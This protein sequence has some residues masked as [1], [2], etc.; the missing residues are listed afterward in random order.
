M[1][2]LRFFLILLA[3]LGFNNIHASKSGNQVITPEYIQKIHLQAPARALHL[4]DSAEQHHLPGIRPFETDILRTMCYEVTGECILEEKYARRALASD[5]VQLVPSRKIRMLVAL[6]RSLVEQGKNEDAIRCGEE[7]IGLARLLHDEGREGETL[8]NIGNIYRN[9]NRPGEALKLYRQGI[10]AM[11]KSTNVLILANLSTSYGEMMALLMNEKRLEE[12]VETGKER[13]ALIKRMAGMPGPPPGYIDQQYGFHY[14]KMAYL[15][16]LKGDAQKAEAY[17]RKYLQTDF[18]QSSSNAG[19]IIPY[20]LEAQRY[21]DALKLNQNDRKNYQ[22]TYGNDTINY[23]YLI[24]LD[25]FAQAYRGL[26]LY[27]EADAYQQLLSIV[28]DS[29]YSREQASRA[30]QYAMAFNLHEK[31]LQLVQSQ[32]QSQKR[33]FLLIGSFVVIL[34][35]CALTGIILRNWRVT[36]RRNRIAAKQINELLAQRE[37]ARNTCCQH[38][39]TLLD[40]EKEEQGQTD[41]PEDT[42]QNAAGKDS[43]SLE[44]E[45]FLRME[46]TL[47][48]ENLFLQPD[49]GRDELISLSNTNKNDLPR[50]LRKYANADNVSSYL[51]RLRVEYAIKLMKEKPNLSFDAIAKE[52]SFNSHSTFYRAFYKVCGMTPAQYM[53]AFGKENDSPFE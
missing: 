39:I 26:R 32:L 10:E 3:G 36:L 42:P 47:V 52:A 23:T 49:F 29:I 34:M 38:T 14:S 21:A 25:R 15:L 31:D 33:G 11:K 53:K 20:L 7:A 50:I 51:N 35:L 30:H 9:M 12:A 22:E 5:S 1:K 28:S 8:R 27:K 46:Y 18:S 37:E 19:Q 45:R 41:K 13:E 44:Y 4:L 48:H 43:N 16:M 17:Y 40:A 6:M 24:I 2:I